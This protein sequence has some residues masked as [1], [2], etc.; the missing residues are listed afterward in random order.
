MSA[1]GQKQTLATLGID[2]DKNGLTRFAFLLRRQTAPL[3]NPAGYRRHLQ[4]LPS[5]VQTFFM[6]WRWHRSGTSAWARRT[7]SASACA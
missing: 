2:R 5:W 6:P 7:F 1:L 4:L 3:L